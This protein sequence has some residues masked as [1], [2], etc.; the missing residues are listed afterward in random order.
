MVKPIKLRGELMIDT[1][2]LLSVVIVVLIGVAAAG[3]H[4]NS[5]NLGFWQPTTTQSQNP[6]SQSQGSSESSSSSGQGETPGTGVYSSG[7]SQS[8]TGGSSVISSS[9]AKTAAQNNL[10]K[11]LKGA[12]AGTPKLS[13]D[14]T[15]YTVPVIENGKQTGAI[16][17]DAKT[18]KVTGGYGSSTG[19]VA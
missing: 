3:Y 17:V 6:Q 18:G 4:I 19:G 13:S 1:K 11:N 12:T 7:Q 14:G 2:I 16:E 15:Y 9:A 10:D 5:Q 8:G